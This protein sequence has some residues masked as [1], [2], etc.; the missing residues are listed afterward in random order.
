MIDVG[1]GRGGD[2]V[3]VFLGVG[4]GGDQAGAQVGVMV[5]GLVEVV[6]LR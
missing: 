3:G 5:G 6:E 1:G 2:G 4:N